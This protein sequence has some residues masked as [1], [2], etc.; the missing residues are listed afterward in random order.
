LNAHRITTIGLAL[1]AAVMLPT[2]LQATFA[3]RSFFEDFPFGRGWIAAEG[4]AY[5]EHLVR[6][7][8]G[9]F[10]AM[11]VMTVWAIWRRQ[12]ARPVAVAWLLQGF[13]HL[14][15]HAGHLDAYDGI[16][17]VGL[18]GSLLVVPALALVVLVADSR[19]SGTVERA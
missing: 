12:V 3:P 15:Y 14:G 18:V 2:A 17:R 16:D 10:L 8:G 19:D 4:G 9:L 6:D 1:I 7:V 13:L 11:I 5:D